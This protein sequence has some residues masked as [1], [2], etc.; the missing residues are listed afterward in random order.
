MNNLFVPR[1][2]DANGLP[3]YGYS[4]TPTCLESRR[5]AR[6][7][8][9]AIRLNDERK[10]T[11]LWPALFKVWPAWSFG[12]QGTGDCVS[13]GTAHIL[14]VI[15]SIT[16]L[17]GATSE[18]VALVATEGIYGFGKSELFN[19]YRWNGQGM[20][21]VDAMKSIVAFGT[22]YR[23]IYQIKTETCDLSQYDGDRA[24]A[25]GET[26]R[27][28]HGVPDWLEP[29][30]KQHTAIDSVEVTDAVMAGALIQSGYPF[31]WC[32]NTKWGLTRDSDGIARTYASG[33]HCMAC[34]GV[35]YRNGDPYAFWIANTGHG[36]HVTG[37]IGPYPMPDSYAACGSWISADVVDAVLKDGDCFTTSM[38]TG[39]EP[40]DL[41]DYGTDYYL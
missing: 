12:L 37:P 8:C 41:P 23:T 30:A 27:R 14:D 32:G 31:Q 24:I 20:A 16:S 21:G 39:W 28:S 2:Q 19:S 7:V 3:N 35:R 34:T 25:W 22:L 13:W 10:D 5:N 1:A 36:A 18:A 38:I 17:M 26:P 4:R 9:S 40:L 33:A 6:T 11:I 29:F 15:L